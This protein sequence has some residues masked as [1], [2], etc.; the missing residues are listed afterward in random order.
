MQWLLP[1]STEETAP[2]SSA[3]RQ[4]VEHFV[5]NLAHWMVETNVNH[6]V[7][8]AFEDTALLQRLVPLQAYWMVRTL[9]SV[10]ANAFTEFR[11]QTRARYPIHLR[12]GS[13]R[14]PRTPRLAA[15]CTEEYASCRCRLSSSKS[16]NGQLYIRVVSARIQSK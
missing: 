6:P 13:Y 2:E 7:V 12:H 11:M 4:L 10:Q 16:L 1:P 8:Q 14:A 5:S 3:E 9:Q 15:I